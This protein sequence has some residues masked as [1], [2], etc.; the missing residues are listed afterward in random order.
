M[1]QQAN[2]DVAIRLQG[3]ASSALP[4]KHTLTDYHT[5]CTGRSCYAAKPAALTA[6]AMAHKVL[7]ARLG[8]R[9]LDSHSS[10]IPETPV[11]LT[12]TPLAQQ[13]SQLHILNGLILP[14]CHPLLPLPAPVHT[15]VK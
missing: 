7:A 14:C 9:Y 11:H 13:G 8:V 4:T 6:D 5:V 12:K 1:V 2:G 10:P 15:S 3:T